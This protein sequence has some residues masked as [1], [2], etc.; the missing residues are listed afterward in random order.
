M[1][2][3]VMIEQVAATFLMRRAENDWSEQDEA[4]FQ[5]W[6]QQSAAHKAA[7]WRLEYGYARLDRMR[8]LQPRALRIKRRYPV[9]AA[10]TAFAATVASFGYVG[11]FL[12][13][14]EASAK[15][16]TAAYSTQFGQ[17]KTIELADGSS[18]ALNSDSRVRVLEGEGQRLLWLDRGEAYFEVTSNERRPFVVHAGVGEVTV[19]GTKFTVSR[20]AGVT[21]VAVL[22]G[23]VRIGRMQRKQAGAL[24]L[25]PGEIGITDGNFLR[26][27]PA[28]LER[29]RDDIAWRRGMVTFEDTRVAEAADAFNRYNQRKLIISDPAAEDIRIG[30]SFRLGN[31]EGFARLLSTAYGLETQ[32]NDKEIRIS[33]R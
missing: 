27:S 11:Y 17:I 13:I 33:S 3:H 22:E 1:T 29:L 15:L 23:R 12:Y 20:N 5:S 7:F 19:L 8:A 21:K 4:E 31:A 2:D 24:I 10:I 32:I 26:A 14:R 18:V 6:L 25:T 30:G 28:N 9:V 16:A